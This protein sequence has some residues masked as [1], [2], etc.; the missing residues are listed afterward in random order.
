MLASKNRTTTCQTVPEQI[1]CL[2]RVKPVLQLSAL[3]S[4]MCCQANAS[5]QWC[6][7]CHHSSS[8]TCTSWS[9]N[10]CRAAAE[11]LCNSAASPTQ[12]VAMQTVQQS[13]HLHWCSYSAGGLGCQLLDINWLPCQHSQS[14][15]SALPQVNL[16]VLNCQKAEPCNSQQAAT[17][18][19]QSFSVQLLA[20]CIS[21]YLLLTSMKLLIDFQAPPP[22]KPQNGLIP[23]SYSIY[24]MILHYK[25]L[26]VCFL[27]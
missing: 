24:T 21:L 10:S 11:C 7:R 27:K 22:N 18:W 16:K 1:R 6:V 23:L 13:H 2:C 12:E 4:C 15:Y 20:R 26:K 9:G 17:V 3:W 19:Q 8:L 25:T 5:R 14:W